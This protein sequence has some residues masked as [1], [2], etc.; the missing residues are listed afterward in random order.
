MDSKAL[1]LARQQLE[2]RRGPA[3]FAAS[4]DKAYTVPW[5]VKALNDVLMKVHT[6]EIKRLIIT[7]PPRHSKSET[8]SKYMSAWWLGM[9]PDDRVMLASYEA[10]L[11]ASWGKKARDILTEYG[12]DL[13]GVHVSESSAASNRWDTAG[14]P[15]EPANKHV[16]GM[17]TVGVGGALTGRGANLLIIDDYLRNSEDA[18]SKLIRV[19]QWDWWTGT[20]RPR[21]EPDG[22]VIII[23]TRWHEDD[24]I[25]HLLDEDAE[26]ETPQ[27]TVF[28]LPALAEEDEEF[29]KEGEALWPARYDVEALE[30]IRRDIKEYWFSAEYQCRP[31]PEDGLIFKRSGVRYWKPYSEGYLLGQA[32]GTDLVMKASRCWN[33]VTMD[34]AASEKETADFTVIAAW[35]VTPNSDMI[36]MD[37][38]RGRIMGPEKLPR[39]R[40]MIDGRQNP[41]YAAQYAAI[42]RTG[43]QLDFVKNARAAGMP[44]TELIAKGDKVARAIE[45][46]IKWESGQIYIPANASWASRFEE[47]LYT[48]DAGKHDDQVDVTAYAAIE[49]GKRGGNVDEA[50]GLVTCTKCHRKYTCTERTGLTRPCPRCGN[51][52]SIEDSDEKYEIPDTV[53]S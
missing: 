35:A 48:F 23:A 26:L 41:M 3:Y 40:E 15:G 51:P 53:E 29:R 4:I 27:W 21:L 50:Y 47:E 38:D 5:H 10:E 22:C 34:L 32:N 45:A 8:A 13:F 31:S 12:P 42:E 20:A 14:G 52:R 18:R 46:S 7:M 9:R 16:G 33:F 49:V 44:I 37:L 43:F 30:A 2:V 24:L 36:L 1:R 6:G 11:A 17:V 25:G 39:L 19:K 28:R